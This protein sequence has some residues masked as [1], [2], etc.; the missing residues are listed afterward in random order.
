MIGVWAWSRGGYALGFAAL[1]AAPLA[2]ENGICFSLALAAQGLLHQRRRPK[3]WAG[4]L[5][6]ALLSRGVKWAALGQVQPQGIGFI[7]NPLAYVSDPVRALNGCG[8]LARYWRLLVFPWPLSADYSYNQLPVVQDPGSLMIWAPIAFIG[9][10]GLWAWRLRRWPVPALWVLLSVGAALLV[11]SI[12]LPSSTLFAERLVYLPATGFCLGWGWAA[13]R[14]PRRAVPWVAGGWCLVAIPLLWARSADWKDDLRLF[15][16]TVLTAPHSARSHYGLGRALHERQELEKALDAYARALRLYPRYAEAHFNRGAAL[17]A[18]G[19][20]REALDAYRRAVESR[21]GYAKALYAVA[22]L[23]QHLEGGAAAVP[24]YRALLAVDPTHAEGAK[25][26]GR[27]LLQ[28]GE[29]LQAR[30]VLQAVAA[31]HPGE[32]ELARLLEQ[33]Q[34]AVR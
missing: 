23:V 13:S 28:Q 31:A 3:L 27:L 9:G 17:L 21:P 24:A 11:A 7:D 18:L 30:Q 26:L 15:A 2:K 4:R 19:R 16:R 33:A 32:A 29:A 12:L 6:A 25:A 10:L 8:V 5:G 22:V 1:A 34:A 14:L 20:E